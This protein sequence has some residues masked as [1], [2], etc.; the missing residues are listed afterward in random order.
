[1]KKFYKEILE[2][3]E[4]HIDRWAM[5]TGYIDDKKRT[6]TGEG[7]TSPLFFDI[8]ITGGEHDDL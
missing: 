1:M 3:G 4:Y 6:R 7:L 5:A 8:K 2:S